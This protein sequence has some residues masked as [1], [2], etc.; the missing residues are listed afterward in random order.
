MTLPVV[1]LHALA[2]PAGMWAGPRRDLAALGHRVLAPDQRGYGR[3]PLGPAGPSLDV[4]V[5]DLARRLDAAGVDRAALAGCSMGGYL[6]MA[7]LRRHPDR[8]G[9]L[10]LLGTR[11]SADGPAE[12]AERA[13][14]ARLVLDERTRPAVLA[15]AVPKLL[16]AGTR[17]A[18]PDVVDRVAALVA[19]TAAETI[20]WCQRAAADRPDSTALLH[21][22]GLPAVVVAGAEDELVSPAEAERLAAALPGAELVVVPGA[23]HLTPVEAPGAV[24]A[25]IAGLLARTAAGAG[26]AAAAGAG[27][28]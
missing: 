19:G 9:A 17:A 25:A 14:F 24:T 2:V 3:I 13:G 12:R 28:C 20:A 26:A 22:A 6:A 21:A 18:R 23:G 4:L 10:A 27:R 11:A 8:V 16:G 5:D 7:F 15:A 1:L